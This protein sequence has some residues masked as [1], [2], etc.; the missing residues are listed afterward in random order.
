M[1][2]GKISERSL[3]KPDGQKGTISPS[4][5]MVYAC[6]RISVSEYKYSKYFYSTSFYSDMP[7]VTIPKA[8]HEKLCL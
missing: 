3:K 6:I 7:T 1:S 2:L 5:R 8:L 4:L